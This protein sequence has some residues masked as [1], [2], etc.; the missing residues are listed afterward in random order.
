[1]IIGAS[2][3]AGGLKEL[4]QHVKSVEL[5]MPKL[6][7]YE[8]N[9][10]QKD[11]LEQILDEL[12]TCDLDT[13]MHA[14]YFAD[15]PTYPKDLVV[16]TASME[17]MHFKLMEECIALAGKLETKAV[18]I[19]PGRVG[20]DRQRSLGRM[21]DNLKRLAAFASENNVMLGLENKEATDPGNLCCEA[22][23]LLKVVNEVDSTNLGVTFDI[24]HANLTCGGEHEKLNEFIR[25]VS[26]QVIH[27]HLHDNYGTWTSNYDGDEHMAPGTGTID[28]SVLNSLKGYKGIFNLEVFSIEDVL[29]GK[30]MIRENI[31]L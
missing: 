22:D 23:E 17:P 2:S 4:D 19:H 14:H 29:A 11:R 5:Y 16:D 21:T 6:G 18:V 25:T 28:Y 15:V 8:G 20:D 24:G 12:S 30:E 3:F 10:L 26:E 9:Y 13:S 7:V 31:S 1:M 27:V